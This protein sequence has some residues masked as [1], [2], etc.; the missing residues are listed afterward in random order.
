MDWDTHSGWSILEVTVGRKLVIKW[1]RI[2]WHIT[3]CN[4]K[5][6]QIQI[7]NTKKQFSILANDLLTPHLMVLCLSGQSVLWPLPGA[8]GLGLV[9]IDVHWPIQR[10]INHIKHSTVPSNAT[11]LINNE[12][13][14]GDNISLQETITVYI[15][16]VWWLYNDNT[17]TSL[18][19][20][21]DFMKTLLS[22]LH[23]V[24]IHL[25]TNLN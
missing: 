15:S 12:S 4:L 6:R 5:I 9:I 21:H 11:S 3:Q 24:S 22:L 10:H 17:K 7:F 14:I 23:T 20:L 25:R 2:T 18:H 8:V 1:A 13:T 16:C 19:R